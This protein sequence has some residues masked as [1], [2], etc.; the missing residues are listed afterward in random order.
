MINFQNKILK[1]LK[2]FI[3][4]N[5]CIF[6]NFF[7]VFLKIFRIFNFKFSKFLISNFPNFEF[8]IFIFWKFFF[9]SYFWNF[10]ISNFVQKSEILN[11]RKGTYYEEQANYYERYIADCLAKQTAVKE[12]KRRKSI[13]NSFRAKSTNSSIKY[14]AEDLKK[15]G[16]LIEITEE[17]STYKRLQVN[18]QMNF[19]KSLNLF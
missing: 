11:S 18:S 12:G 1:F 13:R 8:Q 5:K 19:F 17:I 7:F 6:E 14:S 10:L 15:K 9:F 4:L 16:V 2:F 3:F